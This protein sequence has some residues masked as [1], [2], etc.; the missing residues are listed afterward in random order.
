MLMLQTPAQISHIKRAV[1]SS[2][3]A[4][5]LPSFALHDSQRFSA[6]TSAAHSADTKKNALHVGA[7][8]KLLSTFAAQWSAL[9]SENKLIG[10]KTTLLLPYLRDFYPS[11]FEE[12]LV[13]MPTAEQ[14]YRKGGA[15]PV[16]GKFCVQWMRVRSDMI[17]L[18][19]VLES[20]SEFHVGHRLLHERSVAA[21]HTLSAQ[22]A[23]L[24]EVRPLLSCCHSL[25]LLLDW[26][27]SVS[28]LRAR[29][30]CLCVCR[31]RPRPPHEGLRHHLRR[32]R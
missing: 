2:E 19:Y 30:C 23:S 16:V 25:N 3:D 8:A 6:P 24:E 28:R 9:P 15:K 17:A 20:T 1:M 18:I 32:N 26:S 12:Y 31:N 27:G 22:H 4:S 11:L 5:A 21:V 14:E 7:L 10:A 29:R 13:R